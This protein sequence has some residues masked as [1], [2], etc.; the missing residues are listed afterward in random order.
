MRGQ[1]TPEKRLEISIT[2]LKKSVTIL[3]VIVK[4]LRNALKDRDRHIQELELKL[5]DKELQRKRL[6]ERFYK[7]SSEEPDPKPLGKKRGSLGYHRPAPK[8]ED[9]TEQITLTPICCPYCKRRDGLGSIKDTIIKYTED[10]VITPEQIVK[11][12]IITTHW[13]SNCKEYVRSDKVPAP[14]ERIGTNVMAYILYARYRLRLPYNKIKQSPKDLHH[15]EISE[16][17]IALQLA[18]AKDLFKND[19]EAVIELIKISDTVYCDETGWRIKG[20][21]FWIWVFVAAR[22]IRYVIEDTRGKGVARDAL[23]EKQDRVLI[24]DFYAAYKNI[25]GEN[26]Y[27]WVHLLRDSK[28]TESVFHEDLKGIYHQLKQELVRP[29]E[30]RAY[31]R[32]DKL[33]QNISEKQYADGV[34]QRIKVLQKRITKTR[35]QLLTCLKYERVLPENN[36]AERA[37]RNHVVMRKIFGGSRSLDG[38][39]AMEVNTSVIDTFLHRQPDKGF[40]EVMLP[41]LKELRGE[42]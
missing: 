25:P 26:Q 13:C 15:F 7:P 31:G 8:D 9:I 39:K 29:R 27:C 16:G 20:K 30:K 23:G 12:Y 38:A 37:L 22:G 36:T 3:R 11:K 33:L 42:A 4:E 34:I 40:F 1:L 14:L 24:S 28:D 18:R 6:L 32:L 2:K 19:Y 21:N 10:I 35:P 5:E 17:E 41:K